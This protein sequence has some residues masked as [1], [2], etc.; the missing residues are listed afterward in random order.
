MTAQSLL[1]ERRSELNYCLQRDFDNAM[2]HS[3]GFVFRLL[4]L[5]ETKRLLKV[6]GFDLTSYS[7]RA[8]YE[9]FPYLAYLGFAM[10]VGFSSSLEQPVIDAF[11]LGLN[12]LQDRRK[13]SLGE[14]F[15]DDVALLG[16]ADGIFRLLSRQNQSALPLKKWLIGLLDEFA[17][18]ALWS[19]RMRDVAGDLLDERGRLREKIEEGNPAKLALELSLSSSWP[20]TY[21][22][23]AYPDQQARNSLLKNLLV[24]PI[25]CPGDIEQVAVWLKAL[26][27]LVDESVEALT[28]AVSDIVRFLQRTQHSLKRWIWDTSTRR[29]Q[30]DPAHWLIDNEAHVQSFLWAVLF[31][32]FGQD[33]VDEKYLPDYGQVQSR[34]DLGI[35]KLKLIIEVKIIRERSDFALIEEQVAGDLGLYFKEPERF[36]RMVVYVYDDCDTHFPENYEALRIALMNRERIEDVVIVR[37]PSMIPNRN[38]RKT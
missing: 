16:I 15:E 10:G 32:I 1:S 8:K 4:G 28:P 30:V 26:D 22:Y 37:R 34:F 35:I 33:I 25:P 13:S 19:N 17:P 11:I 12:R 23:S 6:D 24:D 31:P 27:V 20:Q 3:K 38:K 9:G 21:R 14:F 7:E 2:I 29:G 36:D 5:D 18:R